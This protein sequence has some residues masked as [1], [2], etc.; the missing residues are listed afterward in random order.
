MATMTENDHR[1]TGS[2][3][4]MLD[5]A[6]IASFVTVVDLG[7]Y[8]Q[9][10]RALYRTQSAVSLQIRRLEETLGVELF[11]HPRSQVV[12]S[13]HGEAFLEYARRMVELNHQALSSVEH[14][15]LKGKIRIGSNHLYA[16]RFLPAVLVDFCTEF[17]E[18]QVELATGSKTT[19]STGLGGQFDIILNFYLASNYEGTVLSREKVFWVQSKEVDVWN[20]D[21]LP[22]AL[23]PADNLLRDMMIEGLEMMGRPWRMVFESQSVDANIAA[24]EAGLGASICVSSRLKF[25]DS[26]LRV[27][28]EDSCPPLPDSVF[29]IEL[30]PR[31]VS[32]ATRVLHR[33]LLDALTPDL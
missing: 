33:Y 11:E 29:T 16:S 12:L 6:L 26:L 18:V 13:A 24:A 10:A 17:P 1:T 27:I 15:T 20:K 31:A 14:D 4:R 3:P 22:V 8:T 30:A 19:L 25:K 5:N 32:R 7:S 9:A 2:K 23:M 28:P 21:P